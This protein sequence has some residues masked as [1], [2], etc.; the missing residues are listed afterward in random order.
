VPEIVVDGETGYL[1]HPGDE[2]A[3]ADAIERVLQ[4]PG[5]ANRLGLAGRARAERLFDLRANV[6]KLRDLLAS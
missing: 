5:A 1:V 4:D 2:A 3:L 6:A